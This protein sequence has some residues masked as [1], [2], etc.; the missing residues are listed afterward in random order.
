MVAFA[1]LP[2][3][4]AALH[5][6]NLLGLTL[7]SNRFISSFNICVSLV[8][9]VAG[10]FSCDVTMWFYWIC[11]VL[12]FINKSTRAMNR[13]ANWVVLFINLCFGCS[14]V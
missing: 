4:R 6:C 3:A 8:L 9:F 5:W 13:L 1:S 14:C 12:G 7:K 11:C 10:S 2:V